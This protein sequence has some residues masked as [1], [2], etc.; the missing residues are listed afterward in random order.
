MDAK[1]K[2]E[3]KSFRFS[4]NDIE[5][6][7]SFSKSRA[8][9]GRMAE[10]RDEKTIG[11]TLRI[12]PLQ[13][14]WYL[15]R[16]DITL[17]LGFASELGLDKARY[18]ADQARLAAGRERDL[19]TFVKML[20]ELETTHRYSDS[21]NPNWKIA[22]EVADPTSVVA[23]RIRIGDTGITWTWE[24]LINKFLE[25]KLPTLKPRYRKQYERYL[26]LDAFKSINGKLASE[27]TL[28]D[29]ERVRDQI[30]EDL[31]PSAVHRAVS[32]SK[33]MLT[34]GR[35]V[36]SG[37]SGLP[38]GRW[39]NDWTY[40]YTK[41]KERE[42]T[43]SIADIARTLVIADR[44]RNLAKGEHETYP[45]TVGALWGVALTGQRTGAFMVL[46]QDRLFDPEKRMKNLKGWKIANWTAE[47]MKGGRHGGRA[48][49]LPIPPEALKV[50]KTFHGEA[51][52]NSPWMFP[53]RDPGKHITQSALNLAMYRLQ[54]RVF[55]HTKKQKPDR[56]GKPGPKP[57]AKRQR[58]NLFKE[59][60]IQPW[61]LHDVR[62]T[63]TGFLDE[64]RLGGAA[65]A[66]LGHRIHDGEKIPTKERMAPV[67]QLHY[68]HSQ[69]I[70]LKAQGMRLWVNALLA[71]CARE[72]RRPIPDKLKNAYPIARNKKR[73]R[74]GIQ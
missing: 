4:P 17:R 6:A 62:R 46:R 45:G 60:K 56:P 12:T 23:Q 35:T 39:W 65:S 1:Q 15:R 74:T 40:A 70:K 67:T 50:L 64:R 25:H 26:R 31:A 32:Q 48:H 21:W 27:V 30:I 44:H 11:L 20:V 49:A 61:T 54:G 72:R 43:P 58:E 57:A 2:Y 33:I 42:N 22:D 9:I 10:W 41:P 69:K 36:H 14:V 37:R 53:G 28:A 55:D 29:V 8:I 66:I 47:E 73:S 71:A 63:M 38:E 13:A 18:I 19:R 59:Y 7:I 51:G 3:R 34:W 16:R 68:N 5:K 24:A 52:G